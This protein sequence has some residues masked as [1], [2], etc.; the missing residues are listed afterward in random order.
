M[1][2]LD[3]NV[4]IEA[5]NRY[6]GFDLVP[7]FWTWLEERAEAG[8]IA[9][10][11]MIY[12]ELKDGGDDLASWVKDRRDLLFHVPSSSQV[13]ANAVGR[14]GTWAQSEGYKPHVL[15]DFMDGADP[16]LVG[17]AL[18]TGSIVVT[19]E[20]PAGA[21]RKRVKIPDACHHLSVPYENTFEMMRAL[22]A[23]FS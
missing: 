12:D 15:A 17:G 4:L 23:R 18:E 10:T 16:F 21:S 19:Q 1:R 20:T 9:S 7:A 13:V 3:A 5:K 6:Y 22:G 14:L 8:E 2:L 11:D